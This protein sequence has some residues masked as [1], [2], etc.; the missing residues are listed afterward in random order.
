M[1]NNSFQDITLK[2]KLSY[3]FSDRAAFE[4]N[5]NQIAQGRDF[6][7]FLYEFKLMLAGND[8]AGK[9]ILDAY[10]QSSSPP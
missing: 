10:T 4:A 7:D 3:R 9:I 8:K 1:Q 5:V 6:G 2:G